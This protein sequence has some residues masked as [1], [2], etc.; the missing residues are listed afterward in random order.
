MGRKYSPRFII[1]VLI[2]SLL[3]NP[4]A[5]ALSYTESGSTNPD[6]AT[7]LTADN[8]NSFNTATRLFNRTKLSGSVDYSDDEFDY[9]KVYLIKNDQRGHLLEIN[10]TITGFFQGVTVTF[11]NPEFYK[12]GDDVCVSPGFSPLKRS[13]FAC[14][15]GYYYIRIESNWIMPT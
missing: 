15:S 5:A 8:N 10:I 9:F 6:P 1:L 14:Y 11:F 13:F 2:I 3:A 4:I 12:I 7:T